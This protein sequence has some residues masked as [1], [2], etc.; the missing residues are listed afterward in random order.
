MNAIVYDLASDSGTS[1]AERIGAAAHTTPNSAIS[2]S[3]GSAYDVL[4]A[5]ADGIDTYYAGTLKW[6]IPASN[7]FVVDGVISSLTYTDGIYHPDVGKFVVAPLGATSSFYGSI[8]GQ[9]W[10][11]LGVTTGIFEDCVAIDSQYY[12][13][14]AADGIH[15]TT[16][17]DSTWSLE[18]IA[19]IGGTESSGLK[20]LAT[21]YP[22]ADVAIAVRPNKQVR[23]ANSGITNGWVSAT[24][25]PSS[26]Y[27]VRELVYCKNT[28]GS[29]TTRRW[30]LLLSDDASYSSITYSSYNDGDTWG[31]SG[32]PDLGRDIVLY[33]MDCNTDSGVLCAA[34]REIISSDSDAIIVRKAAYNSAWVDVTMNYPDFADTATLRAIKHLG[35]GYWI[36]CGTRN[37]TKYYNVLVSKDDG[38]TW[39]YVTVNKVDATDDAETLWG[40]VSTGDHF[41]ITG[42]TGTVLKSLS[43]VGF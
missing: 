40:I 29:P 43:H 22:D 42:S 26:S 7:I 10:S 36:A 5:L 17:P 24:S 18:S 8:D 38:L 19:A 11:S 23:I 9:Y 34:G 16:D 21:A 39:E 33:D 1:G 14:G 20:A 3:A 27:D 32:I 28:G 2:W 37:E 35:G 25:N 15:Y 6:S 30:E 12:M 13:M 31:T 4:K 41:I